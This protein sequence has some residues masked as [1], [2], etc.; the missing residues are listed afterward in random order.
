MEESI[1][2]ADRALSTTV[3]V[4]IRKMMRGATGQAGQFQPLPLIYQ[5]VHHRP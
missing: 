1:A 3:A 2:G 4:G 5:G